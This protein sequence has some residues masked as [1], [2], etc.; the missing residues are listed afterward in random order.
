M[1]GCEASVVSLGKDKVVLAKPLS[2]MNLSGKPLQSLSHFYS[3]KDLII[4]QDD[5]DQEFGKVRVREH[6]SS[7]GHNGIKSIIESLGHDKFHRIKIGVGK[8]TYGDTANWVLASFS[9]E[10]K[11][12]LQQTVFPI[13]MERVFNLLK[14][15]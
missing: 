12:E 9:L 4:I 10:E 3:I 8:P 11:Q 2:F 13:V 1:Q 5:V 15:L 7:G 14:I 6:G